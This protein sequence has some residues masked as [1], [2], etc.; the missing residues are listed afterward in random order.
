MIT[1]FIMR[2][3]GWQA[4]NRFLGQLPAWRPFAQVDGRCE[5]RTMAFL[6]PCLFISTNPEALVPYCSSTTIQLAS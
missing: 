2:Y 4:R 3:L 6:V 1:S 5:M